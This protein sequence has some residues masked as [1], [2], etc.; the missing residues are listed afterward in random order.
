MMFHWQYS[1]L[2]LIV[3]KQYFLDYICKEVAIMEESTR[4]EEK[5]GEQK[6]G[7]ENEGEK[8]VNERRIGLGEGV[9]TKNKQN[10]KT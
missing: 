1:L 6:K 7:R 5:E 8:E 2:V 9:I 3:I 4:Q 10:N